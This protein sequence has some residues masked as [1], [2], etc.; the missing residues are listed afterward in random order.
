MQDVG[1]SHRCKMLALRADAGCWRFAPMQDVGASRRCR[2]LALRADAG[3]WRFA[4][5]QDARCLRFAPMQD[6][7]YLLSCIPYPVS[8]IPYPVSCIPH[9]ASFL[10]LSDFSSG[11]TARAE[12]VNNALSLSQKSPPSTK[13]L[14]RN[15]RSL[16]MF[17]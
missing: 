14:E 6:A 8:C 3:C 2:M 5:M 10:Q 15:R 9:P 16:K 13:R 1:A 12:K 17:I 4:P 7:R 11:K